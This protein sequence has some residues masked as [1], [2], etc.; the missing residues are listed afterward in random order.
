[1]IVGKIHI[2]EVSHF[3]PFAKTL[4][5]TVLKYYVVTAC[6][7]FQFTSAVNNGA[8]IFVKIIYSY[9]SQNFL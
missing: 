5:G 9:L 8:Q 1:M 4:Y 7:K 6:F 3:E 2:N